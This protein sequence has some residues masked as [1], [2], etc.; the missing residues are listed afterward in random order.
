VGSSVSACFK[1][2]HGISTIEYHANAK[3]YAAMLLRIGFKTVKK[4]NQ[5]FFGV[6][7]TPFSVD[8]NT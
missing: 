1:L 7:A 5:F 8:M 3:K 6:F 4:K 2:T